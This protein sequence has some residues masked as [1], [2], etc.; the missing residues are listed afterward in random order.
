MDKFETVE[1]SIHK[2]E[3]DKTIWKLSDGEIHRYFEVY[4][5][6]DHMDKALI[7]A[8]NVVGREGWF[9]ATQP[10]YYRLFLQRKIK[11]KENE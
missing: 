9:L 10:I 2:K 8:I 11:Q 3:K 6:K 1:L 4:I 7:K 5:G